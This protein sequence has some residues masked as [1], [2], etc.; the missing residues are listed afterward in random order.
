MTMLYKKNTFFSRFK[1]IFFLIISGFFFII[2]AGKQMKKIFFILFIIIHHSF[3]NT[4]HDQADHSIYDDGWQH[5]DNGGHGFQP[6]IIDEVYEDNFTIASALTNGGFSATNNID[7]NNKSF[8]VNNNS[9][10]TSYINAWRYFEYELEPG[11]IFSFSMDVNW[12][13]GFKGIRV[14]DDNEQSLFR[15]EVGNRGDGDATW[16]DDVDDGTIKINDSYS[17]DTQYEIT[18]VQL[19][20]SGGDWTVRRTG[21]IE[22]IDFGKYSGR[23]SRFQIYSL[24][25]SSE[26]YANVHF[27]NFDINYLDNFDFYQ[28][29]VQ[30]F[31]LTNSISSRFS[32]PDADSINNFLEFVYG[33]NPTNSDAIHCLPRIISNDGKKLV[34]KRLKDEMASLYN[35]SYELSERNSLKYSDWTNSIFQNSLTNDFSRHYMIIT[36]NIVNTNLTKFFKLRVLEE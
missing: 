7:T 19:T 20:A 17:D 36:N 12:R 9:S 30:D 4:A 18:L 25:A 14:Q 35:I 27:N 5:G 22:D 28:S 1:N 16:V 13:D 3:S 24:N 11:Q 10:T 29:W 23:P 2:Y 33:G 26:I 15:I 34:Y 21:E 32:D 6:W 31:G 8:S